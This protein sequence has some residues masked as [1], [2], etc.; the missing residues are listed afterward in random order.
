[1]AISNLETIIDNIEQMIENVRADNRGRILLP[2]DN[3][4]QL[5]GELKGAI[6]EE[7]KRYNEKTRELE[8]TKS[9][10]LEKAR[11]NAERIMTEA[12]EMRDR[13]LN[14]NEQVKLAETRAKQITDE[15]MANANQVLSQAQAQVSGIQNKALKEYDDS[16]AFMINYI[17]N[18]GNDIAN[19]MNAQ[20]RELQNKLNEIVNTRNELQQSVARRQMNGNA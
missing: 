14:E 17:Q 5:V 3:L 15:A 4:R 18:I 19:T 2:K 10:E 20:L 6:P 1:M 16:L 9:R 7:I 11:H 12:N 8:Q 13:L